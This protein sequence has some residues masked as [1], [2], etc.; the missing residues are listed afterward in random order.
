MRGGEGDLKLESND[1]N[2]NEDQGLWRV[3][4]GGEGG[5]GWR[6]GCSCI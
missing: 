3:G 5:I 6:D 1:H 2:M 4:G